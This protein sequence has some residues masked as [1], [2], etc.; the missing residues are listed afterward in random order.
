MRSGY[1]TLSI[2]RVPGV[3]LEDVH[4]HERDERRRRVDDQVFADLR[5]LLD[6]HA[7]QR[8]RRPHLRVLHIVK[9]LPMPRRAAHQRERPA[10]EVRQ[11]PV[12]DAFVVAREVELRRRGIREHQPV[13]MADADAGHR[14]SGRA[15]DDDRPGRFDAPRAASV[16]TAARALPFR[17]VSRNAQRHHPCVASAARVRG[18]RTLR[19]DAFELQAAG[20]L[21]NTAAPADNMLGVPDAAPRVGPSDQPEQFTLTLFQ[22]GDARR[23]LRPRIADSNAKYTTRAECRARRHVRVLHGWCGRRAERAR[24]RHRGASAARPSPSAASQISGK[25]R[26]SSPVPS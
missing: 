21:E 14:R 5:L 11:D 22:W 26:W 4:L 24:F 17:A 9:A 6:L 8:R 2:P 18:I 23:I 7:A 1:S 16:A 20:L 15:A 10:G 3:D 13:R 12:G 19:H 25:C